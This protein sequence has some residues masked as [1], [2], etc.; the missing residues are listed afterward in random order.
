MLWINYESFAFSYGNLTYSKF[1]YLES[2]CDYYLTYICFSWNNK[3]LL[4]YCIYRSQYCWILC[5]FYKK[6][7]W[8]DNLSIWYD[9]FVFWRNR[10]NLLLLRILKVINVCIFS[11]SYFLIGWSDYTRKRCEW[12]KKPSFSYWYKDLGMF[13]WVRY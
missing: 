6:E 2:N 11:K 8:Y 13:G 10:F 5:Y 12:N 7:F 3:I 9:G 1:I 4:R